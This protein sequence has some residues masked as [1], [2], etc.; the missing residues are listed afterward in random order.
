[1][2][3]MVR[4]E[5]GMRLEIWRMAATM[6]AELVGK[7]QA[8]VVQLSQ[9]L[10]Q[11]QHKLQE[12]RARQ[13]LCDEGNPAVALVGTGLDNEQRIQSSLEQG[14]CPT[15]STEQGSSDT[16]RPAEQ[17][18]VPSREGSAGSEAAAGTWEAKLHA[19]DM[20]IERLTTLGTRT[21]R[22]F[23]SA[24][25]KCALA[26]NHQKD[27]QDDLAIQH[28]ENDRLTAAIEELRTQCENK[29]KT[30]QLAEAKIAALEA[31][32]SNSEISTLDLQRNPAEGSM[33]T[34]GS[35]PTGGSMVYTIE[36]PEDAAALLHKQRCALMRAM[37][38][39]QSMDAEIQEL[40][41][42]IQ[43]YLHQLRIIKAHK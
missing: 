13:A 22:Q 37:D 10:S 25:A 38:R 31:R 14:A 41:L 8:L 3:R 35:T 11:T 19:K 30:V 40:H 6:D 24:N 1:M 7:L 2:A 34:G 9:Q 12:E 33:S 21:D 16:A 43:T 42:Q 39:E 29:S 18:A 28:G 20:E 17:R 15:Q 36:F 26:E 32:A 5:I 27:L 4:G 23:R